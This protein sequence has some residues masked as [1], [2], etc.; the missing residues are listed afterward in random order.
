MMNKICYILLALIIV[1]TFWYF[2][3][4]QKGFYGQ[5]G[6]P[7]Q[8]L[9][10]FDFDGT[11]CDSLGVVVSEYNKLYP[12]KPI[13]NIDAMRN[14]PMRKFLELHGITKWKLPIM[15]YRLVKAL[16][17]HASHMSAFQGTQ[18]TLLELKQRGYRLGI[19][20]SNSYKNVEGFLKR[21]KLTGLF[22]F[23]YCDSSLFGKARLLQ[24]IRDK[25]KPSVMFYVGDEN[26]DIEAANKVNVVSVAV[27]WGYQSE[28]LLFQYK[29]VYLVKS[30]KE[31]LLIFPQGKS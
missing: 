5:F 28:A 31:L 25:I 11:L 12:A 15:K 22:D 4:Y 14:M 7:G 10:V 21:E 13:D 20:T 19:L 1:I 6:P 29:P 2:V 16:E 18:A 3:H 9:I 27:T 17:Q 24:K 23:I 26:R 8:K 30:M